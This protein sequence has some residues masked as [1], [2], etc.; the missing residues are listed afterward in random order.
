M[1]VLENESLYVE[2]ESKCNAEIELEMLETMRSLK[3]V[4]DSLKAD[5]VKLMNAKSDEEEINE[6]ILKCLTDQALQKNNSQNSCSTGKKRKE[7]TK[8]C[9]SEETTKNI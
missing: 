7:N 2:L 8:I 5:N 3:D 4:I 6:L 9:S 1:T